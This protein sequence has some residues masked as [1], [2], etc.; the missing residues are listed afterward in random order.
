MEKRNDL[1]EQ[2]TNMCGCGS[3]GKASC[4]HTAWLLYE[5]TLH[6]IPLS[7]SKPQGPTQDYRSIQSTAIYIDRY[8]APLD[9]LTTGPKLDGT[10]T[11]SHGSHWLLHPRRVCSG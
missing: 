2:W 4:K 11:V 10:L 3:T 5:S 6:V 8:I 1:A 9:T 7:R